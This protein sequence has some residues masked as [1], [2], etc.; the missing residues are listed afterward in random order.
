MS[1]IGFDF[2]LGVLLAVDLLNDCFLVTHFGHHRV[3]LLECLYEGVDS[4][5]E[6][7]QIHLHVLLLGF[8]VLWLFVGIE[9]FKLILVVGVI[10]MLLRLSILVGSG[11]LWLGA[12][13]S[14]SLVPSGVQVLLLHESV[15]P[16]EGSSLDVVGS[17]REEFA[18]LLQDVLG[19]THED[20]V[21]HWLEVSILLVLW[22]VSQGL[23]QN[24]G[25]EV[26]QDLVVSEIGVLWKVKDGLFLV[27]LIILVVIN[28]D[29]S[30][31]DE[32]HLLDIG[33]V[34]NDSLTRCVNS[35]IHTNN[36]LI[37]ESSLALLKEMVERSLKFFED[38]GV[39][40]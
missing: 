14:F 32:V 24:V 4:L 27:D 2:T 29:E 34:R 1:V 28:L 31:S 23:E 6:L 3:S 25:L 16:L 37:G 20:D 10:S 5:V 38:S 39:L 22:G 36:K 12:I 26:V 13:L 35:A 9:I 33:F 30:L 40:N 8:E 15:S 19:D 17:L 18:Q 21:G 7:V 11:T